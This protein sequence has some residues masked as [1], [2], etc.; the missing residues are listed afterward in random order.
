MFFQTEEPSEKTAAEKVTTVAKSEN[1]DA[2]TLSD[3][4]AAAKSRS[5]RHKMVGININR[6]PTYSLKKP[7]ILLL[8]L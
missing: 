1:V 8:I 4:K 7:G 3:K 5:E 6:V 2:K